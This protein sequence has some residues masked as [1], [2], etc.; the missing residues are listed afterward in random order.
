M[1]LYAVQSFAGIEEVSLSRMS[2]TW[3]DTY[4]ESIGWNASYAPTTKTISYDQANAQIGWN[5]HGKRIDASTT[6]FSVEFAEATT[7]S[8]EINIRYVD[9]GERKTKQFNL[10]MG[11]TSVTC[12][13]LSGFED[14]DYNNSFQILYISIKSYDVTSLRLNR[15]YFT[16]TGNSD[17]YQAENAEY[18]VSSLEYLTEAD[19]AIAPIT[20]STHY[21]DF[22]INVPYAAVYRLNIG[23]STKN[24]EDNNGKLTINDGEDISFT[25]TQ[26]GASEVKDT[27]Y[28]TVLQAGK[29]N[30]KISADD[31][32]F[33]I[34]YLRVYY[35]PTLY[36][37][38]ENH[39]TNYTSAPNLGAL[40]T[41]DSETGTFSITTRIGKGDHQAT[42]ANFYFATTL[43]ENNNS[44]G[45]SYIYGHRWGPDEEDTNVTT[46]GTEITNIAKR[47]WNSYLVPM[48]GTYTITIKAD[49]TSFTIQG[50]EVYMFGL[51]EGSEYTWATNAYNT[52]VY[53]PETKKYTLRVRIADAAAT[54]GDGEVAFATAYCSTDADWTC[55][56]A[57]RYGPS[58]SGDPTLNGTTN[59]IDK[60]G[61]T[62]FT[63]ITAGKYEVVVD[64][65]SATKTAQFYPLYTFGYEVTDVYDTA[66]DHGSITCSTTSK[67]IPLNSSVTVTAVPDAGY[68]FVKWTNASDEQLSTSAE[69]PLTI[70]ANTWLKAWFEPDPSCLLSIPATDYAFAKLGDNIYTANEGP[71]SD[72]GYTVSFDWSANEFG[73]EVFYPVHLEAGTYYFYCTLNNNDGDRKM[74]LYEP[75][76][77]SGSLYYSGQRWNVADSCDFGGGGG[78]FETKGF[79]VTTGDY[80][81]ALFAERNTGFSHIDVVGVCD[82]ASANT[83]ALTLPAGANGSVFSNQINN[84]KIISGT[85]VLLLAEPASDY[86][87]EKW[88]DGNTD[89]P[90][91]VTMTADLSLTASFANASNDCLN[92]ITIQCE[93]DSVSPISRPIASPANTNT[94]ASNG[95]LTNKEDGGDKSIYYAFTLTEPATCSVT[96]LTPRGDKRQKIYLYSA[97]LSEGTSLTYSGKTYYQVQDPTIADSPNSGANHVYPVCSTSLEL[98]AGEYVIG[99][100]SEY[101]WS[102]YDRIVIST[103]GYGLDCSNA[104][105]I[106]IDAGEQVELPHAVR[107]LTVYQGGVA[108]NTHDVRIL[109]SVSYVR[110]AVGGAAGNQ[111]NHWYP[112][113]L[114]FTPLSQSAGGCQVYDETDKEWYKINPVYWQED[115]AEDN[116][117]GEGYFYLEYMENDGDLSA[118][119]DEFRTRWAYIKSEMPEAYVPYIIL[120]V[121]KWGDESDV[122]FVNNPKVKF[123]GGPQTIEGTAKTERYA[124]DGV[125]YYYYAN[126]TLAPISL[127]SA[128]TFANNNFAYRKDVTV[129]PFECYIQATESYKAKHRSVALPRRPGAENTATSLTE[130]TETDEPCFLYDL[131]GRAYGRVTDLRQLPQGIWIVKQ[132]AST[133]KIVIP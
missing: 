28:S 33:Y 53:N 99:L 96:L 34:D 10:A 97:Q 107:N 36:L 62:K 116:P 57:N 41:F 125:G 60:N 103:A 131:F 79:T 9:N 94:E 102:Q 31:T 59:A 112:F 105:D 43:A 35:E 85:D 23:Y 52:M 110:Y 66:Y 132:G 40:M 74:R 11:V 6:E 38:G 26:T 7:A 80:L 115:D 108:T 114:P 68:R 122:Y 121:N 49:L 5:M 75:S 124:E 130:L 18:S 30:V 44:A 56:N 72:D 78:T 73:A 27:A 4:K 8:G 118:V 90:R 91:T 14:L 101:S 71:F 20:E 47:G 70:T 32:H 22:T 106:T 117:T 86:R 93:R 54:A 89:N 111:I 24:F 3:S 21:V 92:T 98:A 77:S 113:C 65:F 19:D 76:I 2:S 61:D 45:W 64:M 128:Y 63:D 25:F 100:Y 104:T 48:A 83:V 1:L 50:P 51:F 129:A 12:D 120:F 133:C 82:G 55:L 67:E 42:A 88:S 95:I 109:T 39:G 58:P 46:D 16:T 81:I 126:N 15:A 87:F 127:S 37:L 29:N 69:Y 123:V 13:L 84:A 119:D 17:V